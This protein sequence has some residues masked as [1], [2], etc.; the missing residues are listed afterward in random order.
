[1]S[2][3]RGDSA[4]AAEFSI[5]MQ[6]I[7]VAQLKQQI[8]YMTGSENQLIQELNLI[9]AELAK[10]KD[11]AFKFAGDVS[12]S[13]RAF[14]Q[15]ESQM[16]TLQERTRTDITNMAANSTA[17]PSFKRSKR[18]ALKKLSQTSNRSWLSRTRRLNS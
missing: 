5:S 6:A 18:R 12:K 4:Y 10:K 2:P 13:N 9:K 1:M 17:P 15:L 7:E 16:T 3:T 8:E 11:E 14:K